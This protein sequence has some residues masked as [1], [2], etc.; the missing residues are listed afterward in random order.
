M[1]PDKF[2]RLFKNLNTDK[3]AFEEV[4]TEYYPLTVLHLRRCYGNLISAEDIAHDL[5]VKLLKMEQRDYIEHPL[6]WVYK[7]ADNMAVDEIRKHKDV[8][9]NELLSTPVNME[10]ISDKEEIKEYFSQLDESEVKILYMHFWEGYSFKEIAEILD[11]KYS[12]V[13]V[14]VCRAY[15]KFRD[16]NNK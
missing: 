9:L 4:Y 1:N 16:K 6:S 11:I 3:K 12:N 2:N 10:F 14:K 15:K 5:F 7:L 8:P 13:R